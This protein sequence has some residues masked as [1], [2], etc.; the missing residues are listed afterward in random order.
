MTI[1]R[2]SG[3]GFKPFTMVLD[4]FSDRLEDSEPAFRAMAEFQ[5]RTV[6]ARQFKQQ[7]T[8]ETGRW[9]PLS[10][11]YASYKDRV[12]PGRPILVFDGDLREGLTV[13]GK[14]I[15]ETYD[16]G[17]VVGTDLHYAKYHQKGTPIMPARP[18]FGSIRRSDVKQFAKLLQRWIVEGTI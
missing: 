9:A 17:F 10:P 15:F 11:P 14:G 8:P 7:G 4:R 1:V 16:K 13:P 12:R 3:A 18:L 6:N 2:F 5:V